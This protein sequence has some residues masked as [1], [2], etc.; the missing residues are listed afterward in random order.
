[1]F[2]GEATHDPS[3]APESFFHVNGGVGRCEQFQDLIQV[4]HW[5][6]GCEKWLPDQNWTPEPKR[7]THLCARTSALPAT[8][9]RRTKASRSPRGVP[10]RWKSPRIWIK[11]PDP[12]SL[13]VNDWAAT[14][15]AMTIKLPLWSRARAASTGFPHRAQKHVQLGTQELSKDLELPAM[16]PTNRTLLK[17]LQSSSAW[18]NKHEYGH[19]MFNHEVK[20]KR[21]MTHSYDVLI[22]TTQVSGKKLCVHPMLTTG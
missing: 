16:S 12:A 17:Y 22:Q 6:P 2:I 11:W 7:M 5:F 4:T 10:D 15:Q 1:M 8:H 21:T 3:I 20:T 18:N 19:H 13:T 9:A 14:R